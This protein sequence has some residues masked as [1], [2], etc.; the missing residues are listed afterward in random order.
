[1]GS[2][3][4][5]AG[6]YIH[7]DQGGAGVT[8][9][10]AEAHQGIVDPLTG[11]YSRALLAPRLAEE[12][13]RAARSTTGF[14]VTLFDVDYFKSVNDAYGHG[15]GAQVLQ[16]IAARATQLVRAHDARFRYGDH[17]FLL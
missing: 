3:G 16:Q 6:R 12:L 13:A 7:E 11:A 17:E 8:G 15:R 4:T 1:M 10:A 5:A 9:D 2:G 14:A